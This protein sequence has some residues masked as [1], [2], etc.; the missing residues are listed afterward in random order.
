MKIGGKEINYSSKAFKEIFER[1]YPPMCALAGRILNDSDKAQD[2]AQ[3]AFVKLWQKCDEAFTDENALRAYLY[4]LVKN[5]CISVIRKEKRS[6]TTDIEDGLSISEKD[7]LNEVL[8]EE[9]YI[10]LRDAIDGLSQQASKVITLALK[11]LSNQD[12]AEDMGVTLNTIKTVKKRAYKTLR[13]KLGNQFVII[14]LTQFI[15][16]F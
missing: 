4:V 11:G 6:L 7:F 16:F 14:L 1:L 2:V 8:R 15:D 5:S 3:E 12:I 10:L 9:T 13:E